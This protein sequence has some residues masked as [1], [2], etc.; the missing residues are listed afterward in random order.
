MKSP[1]R[2]KTLWANII[3][4][5]AIFA[6]GQF[7]YVLAAEDQAVALGAVNLI[8]RLITRDAIDWTTPIAN[9]KGRINRY[10]VASILCLSIA[11][12]ALLPLMSGCSTVKRIAS[13]DVTAQLVVRAAA[14]RVLDQRPDWVERTYKITGEV[15]QLAT[16]NPQADLAGLEQAVIDRVDWQKLLPEE[17]ALV[18]TLIA[19]ARTDLEAAL[20]KRG[21]REPS[22][23]RVQVL[24]ILGYIHQAAE[25][26]RA[27][28][29]G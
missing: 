5:G 17:Q 29:A 9:Q 10:L 14:G 18:Q 24:R 11:L 13:D 1:L 19:A 4:I 2:S 8:L 3:A 28:H 15:I 7:G 20:E 22:Q 27:A 12:M 16:D 23:V 25:I 21:I 6:Q 26:R